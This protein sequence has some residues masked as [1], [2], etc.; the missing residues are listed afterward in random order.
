MLSGNRTVLN[1]NVICRGPADKE[2]I[3]CKVKGLA[4][5]RSF[6]DAKLG[7]VRFPVSRVI[8]QRIAGNDEARRKKVNSPPGFRAQLIRADIGDVFI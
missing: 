1:L 5:H 3:P 4:F 8:C 7:H 6:Y 2:C